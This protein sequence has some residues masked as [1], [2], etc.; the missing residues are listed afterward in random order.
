MCFFGER[1]SVFQMFKFHSHPSLLRNVLP[2]IET[3]SRNKEK[4]KKKRKKKERHKNIKKERKI[5]ER[6]KYVKRN[7]KRN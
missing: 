6:K 2:R 7:K 5:E 3:A 4:R 1:E